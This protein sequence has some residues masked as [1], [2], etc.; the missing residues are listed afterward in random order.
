MLHPVRHVRLVA[1][2]T[3]RELAAAAVTSQPTIAGY[4]GGAKS[5]TWRTIDRLARSVGL[6]CHSWV[7]PP[8]TWDQARSLALHTTIARRFQE[9]PEEIIDKARRNLAVMR[10]ANPNAHELLDAWE[11]ILDGTSMQ[12]VAAML[13][14]SERGRDMRQ[15]T[16]FAGVLTAAERRD[17]LRAFRSAA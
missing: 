8:M 1:G 7:G 5:P 15:V 2:V 10:A 17:A 11:A 9:R 13:D 3:Q 6:E 16:P 14:P 4:E 12:I